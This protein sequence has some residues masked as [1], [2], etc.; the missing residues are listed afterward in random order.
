M[1]SEQTGTRFSRRNFSSTFLIVVLRPVDARTHGIF[2]H[3]G[4][5][6]RPETVNYAFGVCLLLSGAQSLPLAEAVRGNQ[7]AAPP[8][9]VT[10]RRLLGCGLRHRIDRL[11]TDGRILG[12][13]GNET[14]AH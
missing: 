13:V 11:Q 9:W 6:E 14:P 1:N 3:Q 4:G 2:L 12:P 10:K 5:I 8:H 7:A